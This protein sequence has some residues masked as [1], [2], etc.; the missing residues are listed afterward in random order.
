[1]KLQI[2]LCRTTRTWASCLKKGKG[3]TGWNCSSSRTSST[4]LSNS[5]SIAPTRVNVPV[6]SRWAVLVAIVMY[7]LLSSRAWTWH[8]ARILLV[9]RLAII[10][11]SLVCN[12]CSNHRPSTLS[13]KHAKTLWSCN[14]MQH[15]HRRSSS[16]R[17]ITKS[18]LT[19]P[20]QT[21]MT[22]NSIALC[23]SLAS[24]FWMRT[25]LRRIYSL[26]DPAQALKVINHTLPPSNNTATASICQL[27][28]SP[29]L[30]SC[31]RSLLRFSKVRVRRRWRVKASPTKLDLG[32][33]T[34]SKD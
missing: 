8:K 16:N 30:H 18:S 29:C 34:K 5:I 25:P 15:Q 23:N 27:P 14:R 10:K 13:T 33:W 9:R 3:R 24:L 12:R 2:K 28:S 26:R 6:S 7:P 21:P 17:I 20:S 1:M 31:R 4:L 22:F 19:S 32:R 11:I